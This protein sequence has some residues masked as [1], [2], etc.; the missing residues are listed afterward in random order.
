[1]VSYTWSRT[2]DSSAHLYGIRNN[3]IVKIFADVQYKYRTNPVDKRWNLGL[4]GVFSGR[5]FNRKEV[6]NK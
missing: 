2:R 5:T 4:G 6:L 3:Y 1:M